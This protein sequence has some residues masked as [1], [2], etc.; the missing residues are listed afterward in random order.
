MNNPARTAARWLQINASG[1]MNKV[2]T[3]KRQ[4]GS[5]KAKPMSDCP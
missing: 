1:A 4:I 3:R 2:Q 5:T